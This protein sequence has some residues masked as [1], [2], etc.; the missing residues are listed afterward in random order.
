MKTLSKAILYVDDDA[1]DLALFRQAVEA[2]G[3][4]FQIIEAFDGLHGLELLK[5]MKQGGELPCLIVL[6][7]N[8]PRMD[9]KQTLVAIQKDATLAAIPIVLF[10]TSSSQLDKTFSQS[11]KVELITKPFSFETLFQITRK[12]LGYCKVD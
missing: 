6:D 12:M 1:D 3:T 11:K 7:I 5:Q 4:G 10:S 9:G 2:I 8:M